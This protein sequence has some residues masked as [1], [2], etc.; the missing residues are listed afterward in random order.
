MEIKIGEKLQSIRE[1]RK[2][3]QEDFADILSMSQSKYQRLESGI[4]H[5]R[6][7]EIAHIAEVLDIPVLELLP[8]TA[9]FKQTNTDQSSGNILGNYIVNKGISESVKAL[10]EENHLLLQRNK[11]LEEKIRLLE[12]QIEIMEKGK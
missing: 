12:K 4:T 1:E 3:S 7:D 10:E 8:E 5:A 9:I 6:I 11:H 2:M